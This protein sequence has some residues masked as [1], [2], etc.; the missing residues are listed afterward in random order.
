[1]SSSSNLQRWAQPHSLRQ[2]QPQ[3]QHGLERQPR[4]S[5]A[6]GSRRSTSS[7]RSSQA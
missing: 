1:L 3:Q 7:A 2:Q 4:G 5:S 6:A